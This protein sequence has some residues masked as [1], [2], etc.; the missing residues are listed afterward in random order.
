MDERAAH[1]LRQQEYLER[2]T[3][4]L[5]RWQEIAFE[6]G[7]KLAVA[8]LEIARLKVAAGE[9]SPILSI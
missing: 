8:E 1:E 6:R 9:V 7:Q 4:R 2:L 3:R 5:E